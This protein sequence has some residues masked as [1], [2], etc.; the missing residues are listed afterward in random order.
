ML[1]VSLCVCVRVRVS[2]ALCVWA[3]RRMHRIHAVCV[4]KGV[5]N[6]C[7]ETQRSSLLCP[8]SLWSDNNYLSHFLFFFFCLSS[9]SYPLCSPPHFKCEDNTQD[10]KTNHKYVIL[11]MH[12]TTRSQRFSRS[13]SNCGQTRV[14][15]PHSNRMYISDSFLFMYCNLNIMYSLWYAP[16][17]VTQ[18]R[19][20]WNWKL[21]DS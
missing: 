17:Q 19:Q 11:I 20:D 10:E 3:T 1:C 12:N 7:C 13:K 9:F 8:G 21:S 16:L 4:V 14:T 5:W 6:S 18:S 2:K 15:K